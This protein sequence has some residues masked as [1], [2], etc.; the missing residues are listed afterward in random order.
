MNKA[1]LIAAIAAKADVTKKDA[2]KV[3]KA[4]TGV[5]TEELQKADGKVQIPEIGSFK[6]SKRAAREVRNPRTN[7]TIMSKECTVP[8]FTAAKALKDAVNK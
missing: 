6:V 5:V 7:E 2:E 8:K 1:E 3:L 4:F